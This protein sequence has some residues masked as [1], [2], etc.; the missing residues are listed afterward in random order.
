MLLN[1]ITSAQLSEWEAYDKIDPV[2]DWRADYR[3]AFLAA[4]ITNMFRWAHGKKGTKMMEVIDFMP[5]WDEEV[6]K[7]KELP[8][9]S[10]EDMKKALYSIAKTQNRKK[11]PKK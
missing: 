5:Q 7:G 1:Q 11:K 10:I 9:Q 6:G 2:G 8:T 3:M 4:V